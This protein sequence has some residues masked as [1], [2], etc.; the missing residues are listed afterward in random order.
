MLVLANPGAVF[1]N[2]SATAPASRNGSVVRLGLLG[3]ER[4]VVAH[5]LVVPFHVRSEIRSDREE[6]GESLIDLKQ[7]LIQRPSGQSA[8]L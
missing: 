5:M 7:G 8:R 1:H 6:L 3:D 4:R 2:A